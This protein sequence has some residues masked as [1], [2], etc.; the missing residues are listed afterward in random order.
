MTIFNTHRILTA[1]N[2]SELL[3]SE[4]AYRVDIAISTLERILNGNPDP[5]EIR[6]ATLVK[7][8]DNLGLPLASLFA[9]PPEPPPAHES[10][11]CHRADQAATDA[12]T[13]TA[14]I[15]D[16]GTTP[17]RN[18]ELAE[19][20]NWDLDRLKAAYQEADRRLRP[21]GLRLIREHGEATIQPI[22]DHTDTRLRLKEIRAA[23]RG[24]DLSHYKAAY[25]AYTGQPIS[26]SNRAAQRRRIT[27]P[28]ANLGILTEVG[29]KA[30]LTDAA[31]YAHP[32]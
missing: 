20:L 16:R 11:D 2:D 7:I 32:L 28:L 15:Y 10:P 18:A 1:F 31:R 3:V 27:A 24:F 25:Q 29:I 8:A 30:A 22:A 19:V 14:T 4:L 21:A 13:V 26:V 6:I 17:T 23:D 9:P 5:G 12:A